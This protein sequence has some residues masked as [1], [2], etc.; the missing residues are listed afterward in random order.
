MAWRQNVRVVAFVAAS[1]CMLCFVYIFLENITICCHKECYSA[2]ILFG[3]LP[4][5]VHKTTSKYSVRPLPRR[6][7][8]QLIPTIGLFHAQTRRHRVLFGPCVTLATGWCLLSFSLTRTY[9][10]R[11]IRPQNRD[12]FRTS[13]GQGVVAILVING[14]W[15]AC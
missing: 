3:F 4:Q 6:A 5:S 8:H 15:Q 2:M 12:R 13:E 7:I 10:I 1:F 11:F 14:P 9:T